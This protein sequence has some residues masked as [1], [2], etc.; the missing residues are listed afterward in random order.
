MHAGKR[1][2]YNVVHKAAGRR[3]I[4]IGKVLAVFLY[5]LLAGLLRVLAGLYF[6]AVNYIGRAVRTHNG[7]FRRGPCEHHVRAKVLGAHCKIRSAVGLAGNNGYLGAGSLGIGIEHLRAVADYSAVFLVHAGQEAGNV[8]KGD[9]RYIEAVAEGDEPC[10]LIGSIYIQ[11]AGHNGGLVGQYAN[12]LPANAAKAG[13]HIF[14]IVGLHL[15]EVAVVNNALYNGL[16]FVSLVAA[17]GHYLVQVF[18]YPVHI[19]S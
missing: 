14:R 6:L 10:G 13:Y 18:A 4:R 1:G 5:H 9:E 11:A 16:H 15:E 12:A 2:L 17:F 8:N 19:V 3:L 7:Y